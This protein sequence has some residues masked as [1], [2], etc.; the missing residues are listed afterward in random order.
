MS[1]PDGS[2][3]PTVTTRARR[4]RSGT[5][6]WIVT[7]AVSVA[8]ALL[9][10]AFLFQMFWIPSESMEPTLEKG[11]RIIVMK[12]GDVTHPTRGDILVFSRP[13]ALATGEEHLI[14]RVVGLPGDRVAFVDGAVFINEAPLPEP[15]LPPGTVTSDLS[16]PGCSIPQPCVVGTNQLWMMGDNRDHSADSRRFGPIDRSTVVGRAFVTVWPVSRIGGL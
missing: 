9:V 15:Y 11:D 1:V 5:L 8:V 4:R 7:I 14:K 16:A 6:S 10:R 3:A 13:P 12:I 2:D